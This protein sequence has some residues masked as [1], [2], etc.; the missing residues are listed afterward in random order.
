[1]SPIPEKNAI[2]PSSSWLLSLPSSSQSVSC[3]R[4]PPE[5][6]ENEPR[7][8]ASLLA[9]A[10]EKTAGGGGGSRARRQGGQ[11][12][13]VATIQRKVRDLLGGNDL[14]QGW[15]RGLYRHF[16]GAN[17]NRRVH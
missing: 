9:G 15:I 13:K 5:E 7:V 2:P 4:E 17:L 11:L 8:A 3:S 1:M 14:A 6:S 12:N 10:G 16:R